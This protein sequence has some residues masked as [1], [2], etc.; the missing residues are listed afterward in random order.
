MRQP[1]F[2]PS[3]FSEGKGL[4]AR[5]PAQV[6]QA[7]LTNQPLIVSSALRVTT[8][9]PANAVSWPDTRVQED[10][11]RIGRVI[12]AVTRSL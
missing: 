5:I 8:A 9:L 11:A 7:R 4:N 1:Q 12:T 2:R 10:A 3:S 6:V